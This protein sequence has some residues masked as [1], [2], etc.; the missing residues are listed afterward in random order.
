[1]RAYVPKP[2]QTMPR[3]GTPSPTAVRSTAPYIE[4]FFG[5]R[6]SQAI[7]T[8][9]TPPARSRKSYPSQGTKA[10]SYAP[11]IAHLDSDVLCRYRPNLLHQVVL[12]LRAPLRKQISTQTAPLRG[13][14][15]Q[16]ARTGPG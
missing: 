12:P 1:M 14:S 4:L 8:H 9:C 11:S 7:G 3:V 13:I 10:R 5:G 15:W 2:S 16:W 6:A